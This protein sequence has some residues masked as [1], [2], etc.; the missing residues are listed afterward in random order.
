M[1]P[2]VAISTSCYQKFIAD[3]I[4]I[5][6]NLDLTLDSDQTHLAWVKNG[7]LVVQPNPSDFL[8]ITNS[9]KSRQSSVNNNN[10]NNNHNP[11][12][13]QPR[14]SGNYKSHYVISC[15]KLTSLFSPVY[16]SLLNDLQR[17]ESYSNNYN[18][19][20][21]AI[22][23]FSV[24]SKK[25]IREFRF[26]ITGMIVC[27]FHV[28]MELYYYLYVTPTVDNLVFRNT[29]TR[30]QIAW[31][32]AA[33]KQEKLLYFETVHI[34]A[35]NQ[36]TSSSK[37]HTARAI[38]LVKGVNVLGRF[39]LRLRSSVMLQSHSQMKTKM[40]MV[41]P[42]T[43]LDVL[44]QEGLRSITFR[45]NL[46]INEQQTTHVEVHVDDS[47]EVS[48]KIAEVAS[49]MMRS[50]S[51]LNMLNPD[52]LD[53]AVV[54]TNSEAITTGKSEDEVSDVSNSDHEDSGVGLSMSGRQN[55]ATREY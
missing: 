42:S 34:K 38:M 4:L 14:E 41:A 21:D 24:N 40:N 19:Y 9:Q 1:T 48:R 27:G 31:L 2:S 51:I 23:D 36:S 32:D 28:P 55:W 22:K 50:N 16:E 46:N 15:D 7:L 30:E 12:D 17:F 10:N 3:I 8:Y 5:M 52:N 37:K 29:F 47:P 45:R 20:S 33:E 39:E 44:K 54:E 25:F 6:S 49:H 18:S 53:K 26:I 13:K 11:F 35:N 43:S